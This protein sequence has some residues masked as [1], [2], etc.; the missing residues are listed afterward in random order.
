[1]PEATRTDVE[2]ALEKFKALDNETQ[3]VAIA[4]LIALCT[5]ANE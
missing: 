1:M 3:C 2:T 5:L 4:T